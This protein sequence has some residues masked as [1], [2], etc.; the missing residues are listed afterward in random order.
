MISFVQSSEN[1]GGSSTWFCSFQE[2]SVSSG[3]ESV[4]EAENSVVAFLP[5]TRSSTVPRRSYSAGKVVPL[6]VHVW[7]REDYTILVPFIRER[8]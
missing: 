2:E 4:L 3:N 5:G 1:E 7:L 6:M 8:N